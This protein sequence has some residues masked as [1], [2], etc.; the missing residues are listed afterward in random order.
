[1]SGVTSVHSN[2]DNFSTK[3]PISRS[4]FG[5]S[6]LPL[7]LFDDMCVETKPMF[8]VKHL[9]EILQTSMPVKFDDNKLRLQ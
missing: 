8:H 9:D 5:N 6:M 4:G 2:P 3:S 7:L 1:V